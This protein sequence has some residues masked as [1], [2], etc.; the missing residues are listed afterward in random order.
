MSDDDEGCYLVSIGSNAL[1][2]RLTEDDDSITGVSRHKLPAGNCDW[3]LNTANTSCVIFR[4]STNELG[5][6]GWF[7]GSIRAY[8]ETAFNSLDKEFWGDLIVACPLSNGEELILSTSKKGCWLVKDQ[9]NKESSS[10][11]R[12][13]KFQLNALTQL[14]SSD[15]KV[16]DISAGLEHVLLLT[17]EGK[18]F[19]WGSNE[20]GQCGLGEK[21]RDVSEIPQAL[22]LPDNVRVVKISAG[23]YHSAVIC[24]NGGLFTFGLGRYGALGTEASENENI[25]KLIIPPRIHTMVAGPIDVTCSAWHTL[26]LN[27]FHEV[28]G[29]VCMMHVEILFRR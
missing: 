4:P 17:E 8:D 28:S 15:H 13:P 21:V 20:Y 14:L 1:G 26:Y 23:W 27:S 25:P 6:F 29:C 16:T 7:G 5:V 10:N 18:L 2:E 9:D 3:N 11:T 24:E 19:V 12:Q 22:K